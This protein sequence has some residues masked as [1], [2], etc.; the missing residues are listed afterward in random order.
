M[1]KRI[2]ILSAI[3]AIATTSYAQQVGTV[4]MTGDINYQHLFLK[5]DADVIKYS[6]GC[7]VELGADYHITDLL[8]AG[9]SLGFSL[10]VITS[11][12]AG[13]ESMSDMYDVRVPLHA[14]VSSPDRK[15]KFDTGPFLD[16]SVAGKTEISYDS[17]SSEKNITRLKD[18]DVNRVS[19][20][21]GV[22]VVLFK[23]L[24][25]GYGIKLTDSVYGKGGQ[26]HLITIGYSF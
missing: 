2:L 12:Y 16:F 26:A 15:F 11:E 21:W 10:S 6:G 23:Y 22:S 14:G 7:L 24:K 4:E 19:L 13:I 18:M 20:G 1:K 9:G 3:L 5:D 8:Y 25:I 17:F